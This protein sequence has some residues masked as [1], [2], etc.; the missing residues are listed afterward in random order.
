MSFFDMNGDGKKDI[1]DDMIEKKVIGD[2]YETD[3]KIISETVKPQRDSLGLR[4]YNSVLICFVIGLC[5]VV[6]LMLLLIIW[7]SSPRYMIPIYFVWMLSTIGYIYFGEKSE[8][9]DYFTIALIFAL[10]FTY[11]LIK[12]IIIEEITWELLHMLYVVP[13]CCIPAW[14]YL[15]VKL[16]KIKKPYVLEARKE[17]KDEEKEPWY[18]SFPAAIIFLIIM[19]WITIR[20]NNP[21]QCAEEGCYRD[22]KMG[23]EYC[24]LHEE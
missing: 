2:I 17:K 6:P 7:L 21:P 15:G 9:R 19:F 13:A 10:A 23:S 12:T 4:I 1:W 16:L 20:M 5:A 18:F 3:E 14:G 11:V 24:Y 22:A 8:G